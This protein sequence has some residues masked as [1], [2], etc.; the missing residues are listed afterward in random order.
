[1]ILLKFSDSPLALNHL[2]QYSNS[3]FKIF[4]KSLGTKLANIVLVL[5]ANN[6][7]LDYPLIDFDQSFM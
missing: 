1:M 2:C 5:S 7:C 6:I 4:L 3:I